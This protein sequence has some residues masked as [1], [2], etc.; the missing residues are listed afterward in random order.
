MPVVTLPVP[1]LVLIALAPILVVLYLM[2]GRQWGGSRA[3]PAGWLTAAAGSVIFFGAGLQLILVASAKA[4]LL[5]LFVLYIIWMALLLYHTINDAGAIS[6]I[7]QEMPGLAQGRAAQA[8]LLSWIFGSFLQGATGFGVPAAVVAPLLVGVGFAAAPAVAIALVGHMW[9]VTFGSLGSSFLSLIAV[10]GVPGQELAGPV[11]GL[12]ALVA[13]GCGLGVLWLA[14]DRPVLRSRILF[15]LFLTAVMAGTQW[16]IA[17]AGLYSLA[18]LGAGLAGLLVAIPLLSRETRRIST[19]EQRRSAKQ[20]L[21][22]VAFIPYGILIGVVM[23]GELLLADILDR[24]VINPSFPAVCTAGGYCT[25]AGHARSISV[26]GHGGA[27]LLYATVLI[28]LWYK[29]RGTLPGAPEEAYSASTILRKTVRGSIRPTIGIYSL[30]AMAVIMEH[31]G[32]TSLLAGVLSHSGVL[33]PFLSPFIGALGAFMTG[34]NTNSN[35]IFGELQRQTAVELGLSV[36]LI[37]AAQN[38]GGAVGSNFAPA[39]VIVGT[40]TV[41]GAN[42]GVVLKLVSKTGVLILIAVGLIVFGLAAFTS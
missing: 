40:S 39:K 4:L 37:L 5:A 33:F 17:R 42:Q 10:T 3:G 11:A 21:L 38:A 32:M 26:F 1:L 25:P 20:R 22:L 36:P 35:V 13:L 9:A 8:L 7:G 30:V 24:I 12:L 29:W 19:P 23:I 28:F 6:A 41:Q 14:E 16:L 2:L 15:V 31:A 34:S 27:L 18:S